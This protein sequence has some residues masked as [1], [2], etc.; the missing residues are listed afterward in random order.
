VKEIDETHK[1]IKLQLN[2]KNSDYTSDGAQAKTH[3]MLV[4]YQI[5]NDEKATISMFEYDEE[6][7]CINPLNFVIISQKINKLKQVEEELQA[8]RTLSA[9]LEDPNENDVGSFTMKQNAFNYR[10]RMQFKPEINKLKETP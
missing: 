7:L 10:S 9:V 6:R 3:Y 2:R 1:I 5:I 4:S 8:Q